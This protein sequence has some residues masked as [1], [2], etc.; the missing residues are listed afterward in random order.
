LPDPA[1]E[2][3]EATRQYALELKWRRYI[4]SLLTLGCHYFEDWTETD[5]RLC[6]ICL[7]AEHRRQPDPGLPRVRSAV[8]RRVLYH[9]LTAHIPTEQ[10]ERFR[11]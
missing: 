4:C 9:A 5:Y 3:R 6:H 11:P 1:A 2:F 7:H 10:R 8:I